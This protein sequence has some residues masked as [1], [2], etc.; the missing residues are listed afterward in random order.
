MSKMLFHVHISFEGSHK[1]LKPFCGKVVRWLCK[2]GFDAQTTHFDDFFE[3]F[4][5]IDGDK[6]RDK[7]KKLLELHLLAVSIRN[8]MSFTV[9][10]EDGELQYGSWLSI[11]PTDYALERFIETCKKDSSFGE[12]MEKMRIYYMQA[13]SRS[14]IILGV[15]LLEDIFPTKP[16]HILTKEE[17][18]NTI[19]YLKKLKFDSNKETKIIEVIKDSDRMATKNR[20][21]RIADKISE[22][23]NEKPS[24]TIKRI[25]KIYKTRVVSAH[26]VSE[27]EVQNA[28]KEIEVI[29]EMYLIKEFDFAR[30]NMEFIDRA[31]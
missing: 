30:I 29:L 6:S 17:R 24:E 20:K 4:F 31:S 2:K 5:D 25:E 28:L 26:S 11:P 13:E 8:R 19:K 3:V 27:N 7:N 14:K 16:V 12:I 23:L 10:D 15:S 21:E 18:E 1:E 22:Y 9:T